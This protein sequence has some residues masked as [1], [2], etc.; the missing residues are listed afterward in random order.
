[1][2]WMTQG[3]LQ[4]RGT[5]GWEFL[6]SLVYTKK[7]KCMVMVVVV[8]AQLCT[9]RLRA[10]VVPGVGATVATAVQCVHVQLFL[11]CVVSVSAVPAIVMASNQP[12][13]TAQHPL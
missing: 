3:R 9:C 12:S 10:G 5:A 13:T 11:R 4:V 6:G 8:K 7:G 2:S 1:M